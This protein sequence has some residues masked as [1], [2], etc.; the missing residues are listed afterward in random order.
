M[1]LRLGVIYSR[2]LGTRLISA[3]SSDYMRRARIQIELK[4]LSSMTPCLSTFWSLARF[5]L[6]STAPSTGSSQ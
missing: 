1:R 4:N 3:A 2:S 5:F 6:P